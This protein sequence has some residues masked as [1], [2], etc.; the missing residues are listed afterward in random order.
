MTIWM[1][2]KR[3]ALSLWHGHKKS[4]AFQALPGDRAPAMTETE[5]EYQAREESAPRPEWMV[6]RRGSRLP[7][8]VGPDYV[9]TAEISQ[10]RGLPP[11]EVGRD[12]SRGF[13]PGAII[14]AHGW[15]VPRASVETYLQSSKR[16]YVARQPKRVV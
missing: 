15:H 2:A 9:S 16:P 7:V 12:I 3:R 13:L 1:I 10:L 6:F 11:R 14:T 4:T 8:S 5:H